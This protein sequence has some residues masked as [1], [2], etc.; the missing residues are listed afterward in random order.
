VPDSIAIAENHGYIVRSLG[1]A[2]ALPAAGDRLDR[3]HDP[4]GWASEWHARARA[5]V[6][7]TARL[8]FIHIL[9]VDTAGHKLGAASPQYA[10]AAGEADAILASLVVRAPDARWFLL[11]DHGHLP[12]GGHGGE[13]AEIRRV[14]GCIVGPGI[15]ATTGGPVHLV[16]VS[17]ALA[18]S[19]GLPLDKRSIGRPLSVA[20]A[21]PLR[22][23]DAIPPLPLGTGA[24]AVA[25][26]AL[27][28]AASVWAVRRW[29][30]APWWFVLACMLLLAVRGM[31]T[32]SM[33][34]VYGRESLASLFDLD[35]RLMMRSWL[36]A[37]PLLVA[38]V[39]IG[40][41]RVGVARTL[42]AQLAVPFAL[43][44]GVL[45]ACH[46]WAPLFGAELAPVAPHYTALASPLLLI[47][48]QGSGAAALA[49][50]ARSALAA[51][52]RPRSSETPRSAP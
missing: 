15:A 22:G 30:L 44:A 35:R 48:A 2:T 43:L 36:A 8:V 31:P 27:G 46:A 11:A 16:D 12:G 10:E 23:D 50:L 1:F 47:V 32:M 7:S 9:R 5:A 13:D 26:L 4:A 51:F 42:V 37:L 49:V 25:L 14:E 40:V 41:P 33:P 28:I 38:C 39:W 24:A 52:G 18:D 6:E 21:H 3:D 29:W 20:L 34:M 17:R 19:L 45:T